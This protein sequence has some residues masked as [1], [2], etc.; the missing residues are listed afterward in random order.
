MW[1]EKKK[2]SQRE[3]TGDLFLTHSVP[4]EKSWRDDSNCTLK[5]HQTKS[6]LI[7][8]NPKPNPKPITIS[9]DGLSIYG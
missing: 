3:H 6:W 7:Y 2:I 8:I 9:F 4:L 5:D 1:Q